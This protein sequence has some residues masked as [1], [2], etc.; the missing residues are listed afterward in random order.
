MNCICDIGKKNIIEP[1]NTN[2]G[3]R[4]IPMTDDVAIHFQAIN[5]DIGK[6]KRERIADGYTEAFSTSTKTVI[7]LWRYIGNT[8]S[9]T[10]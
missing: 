4:K 10:W 5:E 7:R 2:A 9:I 6:P 1:T 3:T 8:A